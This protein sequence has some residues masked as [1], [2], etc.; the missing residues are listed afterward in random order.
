M[1]FSLT[2]SANKVGKIKY[3]NAKQIV[4]HD[5]RDLEKDKHK[6]INLKAETIDPNLT[7]FNQT[8]IYD[9]EKKTYYKP[10]KISE[11]FDEMDKRF[12]NVQGRKKTDGTYS[13]VRKD[14]VC[15]REIVVQLGN[16]DNSY[17]QKYKNDFSKIVNDQSFKDMIG[18]IN[19]TFQGHVLYA[20]IHL[21]EGTKNDH[22]PHLHVGLDTVYK[23]KDNV[24]HFN[25]KKLFSSPARLKRQH[26][27]FY[28]YMRKRGYNVG[29]DPAKTAKTRKRL[30]QKTYNQIRDL[31]DLATE[32]QRL[33]MQNKELYTQMQTQLK[34]LKADREE[35]NKIL[36]NLKKSPLSALKNENMYNHTLNEQ[37]RLERENKVFK[38]KFTK[39]DEIIDPELEYENEKRR[40]EYY[41]K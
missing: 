26:K 20:S 27:Q 2:F 5:C 8:I 38:Q 1:V 33:A 35:V 21:D 3:K 40:E 6:K 32:N 23:D 4:Y 11:V 22:H 36:H 10:K 28:E 16:Q 18:F 7:K 31:K 15:M 24:K 19:Q 9:Q 30:D 34:M 37:K 17:Y 29:Y 25:Q 13:P 14:A 41:K 12:S 39:Y